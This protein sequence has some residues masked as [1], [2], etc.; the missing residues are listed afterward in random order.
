MFPGR[1]LW[2]ALAALLVVARVVGGQPLDVQVT[3]PAALAALGGRVEAID[4]AALAA[5]LDRAGLP[6]PPRVEVTLLA[7]DDPR[8]RAL[9]TWVVGRASGTR[10]VTI[11][12]AR[13]GSYP[14]GSLEGVVWHEVAHLAINL[15]AGGRPVPRWF[16]EGV[17]TSV[18]R[19]WRLSTRLRL[20]LALAADP[21][22]PGVERL[23][24]SD[25]Q[26]ETARAYLLAAAVVADLRVRHGADAPGDVAAGVARGL[27]F[28]EAFLARTGISPAQA[29]ARAW[30]PYRQWTNWVPRLTSASAVWTLILVLAVAAFAVNRRRRAR[31]RAM[32]DEL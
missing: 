8:A 20:G 3:A 25:V 2:L 6:V 10:A 4:R 15:A 12:P 29:A 18:E 30:A 11:L 24:A 14:Y 21:T 16:H 7:G 26:P 17:A 19:D 32:W 23:F 13:V 22:L 1:L 27:P 5:A 28:A 31:R 9:P